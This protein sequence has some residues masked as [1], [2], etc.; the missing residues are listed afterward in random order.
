MNAENLTTAPL[1]LTVE[2]VE[3]RP[4]AGSGFLEDSAEAVDGSCCCCCCSCGVG[5]SE[6]AD[7][8]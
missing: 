3:L 4:S 6:Q 2:V 8:A 5:E 7:I 1:N